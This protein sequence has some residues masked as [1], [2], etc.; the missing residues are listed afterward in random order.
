MIDAETILRKGCKCEAAPN[1]GVKQTDTSSEIN[2]SQVPVTSLETGF[3]SNQQEELLLS[4]EEYQS[5]IA[6][7]IADGLDQFFAG[8]R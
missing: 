5:Q 6:V 4:Q 7:G 2:W 3:L 8:R 1:R